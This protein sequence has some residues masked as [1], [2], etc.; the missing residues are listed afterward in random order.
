MVKAAIPSVA[1]APYLGPRGEVTVCVLCEW[2]VRSARRDREFLGFRFLCYCALKR[3]VHGQQHS[4]I[5]FYNCGK[6]VIIGV[7]FRTDF[8][9]K[10]LKKITMY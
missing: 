9:E 2:P 4:R 3:V 6:R 10:I 8:C 1:C 7:I 5:P